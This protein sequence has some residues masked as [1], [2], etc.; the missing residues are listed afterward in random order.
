MD[1]VGEV[2]LHK[3]ALAFEHKVNAGIDMIWTSYGN[4]GLLALNSNHQLRLLD[5]DIEISTLK[6]S[7]DF[8]C[9]VELADNLGP[10]IGKSSLFFCLFRAGGSFL[11]WG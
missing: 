8:A 2:A 9:N 7:G 6:V 11:L 1:G 10:F 4:Y 3:I 5:L